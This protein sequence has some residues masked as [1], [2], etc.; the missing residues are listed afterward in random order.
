MGDQRRPRRRRLLHPGPGERTA[1]R[2]SPCSPAPPSA[3]TGRRSRARGRRCRRSARARCGRSRRRC[4]GRR[5]RAGRRRAAR[6]R[7]AQRCGQTAIARVPDPSGRDLG[8]QLRLD[9]LAAQAAAGGGQQE[10]RLGAGGQAG[11]EQVLALG[12]RTAPSRSRCLRSRSLRTSFSFSLWGLAIIRVRLLVLRFLLL[13]RKSG[14]LM[15][16]RPGKWSVGVR[17]GGRTLPG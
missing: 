10:A 4:R 1:R 5:H 9:L 15:T 12:R 13:E 11:L 8:Q 17:L 7:S 16:A 14:P 6:A 3:S 2:S